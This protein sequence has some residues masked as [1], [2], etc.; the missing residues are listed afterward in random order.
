MTLF[1]E[2]PVPPAS[3]PDQVA[4]DFASF[5]RARWSG[6][7]RFAYVTTGDAND[8]AD[9]LQ[10]ALTAVYPHW[11][12]V[13][14]GN[15]D[16]Y[17]RRAIVNAH[18]THYR[19]TGRTHARDDLDQWAAPVADV[20]ARIADADFAGRL[21]DTLPPRQRAALVLRYFDERTYADIADI[22]ETTQVNARSLVHHALTALRAQLPE[23]I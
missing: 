21:C 9:V 11:S 3:L 22:L 12:R 18:I 1:K 13:A 14:T 7:T 4:L 2:A 15:P 5:V 10:D 19:R 6:L 8:A 20:T 17:I 16:A 23:R